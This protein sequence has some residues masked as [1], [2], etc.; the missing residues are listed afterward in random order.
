MSLSQDPI[1]T[2]ENLIY[3]NKIKSFSVYLVVIIAITIFIFSLPLIKVDV[4]SQSRGIVRS[5][6]DNV[7]ISAVVS[8]KVLY[9]GLKNNLLVRQGDTLLIIEKEALVTEKQ[10][11]G[12]LSS[13]ILQYRNDIDK[14]LEGKNVMY[15]TTAAQGDYNK[16]LS[17]KMELQNKLT[18][19][20]I[21]CKRNKT[22]YDKG[23]IAKAEYEKYDFELQMANQAVQ[24]YISQQKANWQ[25]Q[26]RE[27]DERIKTL[28]GN[29]DKIAV[30]ENNYVVVAPVTGTIENCSGL[31]KGAYINAA[32]AIAT[33][34]PADNLIVES[35]VSPS[36][37]G[38]IRKNQIVKFQMDAFNYNQWGLLE[39]KVIDIDKNITIQGEQVFF[40]VRSSINSQEITLKSGYETSVSKGMTL[41]T[42]YSIAHRSL[43]DLLFD[44]IDDW[45]NPKQLAK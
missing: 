9:S 12:E 21:T 33:L 3:R 42:R 40:K 26:K 34:S 45:L 23:I 17:G 8:G 5:T 22:L 20:H 4:S 27:L 30:N 35:N 36:D 39:G 19:A 14:M 37:I 38:L 44:K 25:T 1:N 11:Q 31:Q 16:Y 2:I 18:Q 15:E 32:Q 10:S 7:P 6:T 24:S 29:I 41:T 28:K 13:Q 43:F